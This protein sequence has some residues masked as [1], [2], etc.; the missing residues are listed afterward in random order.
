MRSPDWQGRQFPVSGSQ[1]PVA[2]SG[3]RFQRPIHELSLPAA[4]AA[5][6]LRRAASDGFRFYGGFPARLPAVTSGV[7]EAV[8]SAPPWN[9]RFL[10]C[11]GRKSLRRP[12]FGRNV[13]RPTITSQGS[14][15]EV[16]GSNSWGPGSGFR[17]PVPGVRSPACSLR[18][19]VPASGCPVAG[20]RARETNSQHDTLLLV[21]SRGA[22]AGFQFLGPAPTF[23][24]GV[25]R[26]FDFRCAVSGCRLPVAGCLS[27]EASPQ[28]APRLL[29]ADDGPGRFSV[30]GS[31]HPVF[32]MPR[33][34]TSGEPRNCPRS[35]PNRLPG[36]GTWNR[37]PETGNRKLET[38]TGNQKPATGN[39]EPATG[40]WELGTGNWKPET[41][42]RSQWS[43]RSCLMISW[44]AAITSSRSTRDLVNRNWSLKALV[45][46]L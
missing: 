8:A 24:Q 9:V 42:N 45:G 29:L 38:E 44:R 35:S 37:T 34:R 1:L 12:G 7:T 15:F 19:P 13:G 31:R 14:E 32:V 26:D 16:Q 3:S 23:R 18:F 30:P 20:V 41:G 28:H 22:R 10:G 4:P 27:R 6:P 36:P 11:A 43:D 5:R 21:A 46:A 40:N 25:F 2:V 33:P 39:R 17:S